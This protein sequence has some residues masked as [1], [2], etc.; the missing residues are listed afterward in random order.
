M[1]DAPENG[2]ANAND[3]DEQF[4]IHALQLSEKTMRRTA[5]NPWVGAVIVAADGKTIL[6]EGYHHGPGKPH[7]EVEAFRDAEK[8]GSTTEQ[9]ATSTL[10]TTLEPCH[11]GVGKR[12][13]PCDEMIVSRKV[14]RCV[15]GL[16]DPDP[17]FGG[18]GIQLMR[19]AGIDVETGVAESKVKHSLRAYFQHRRHATPFVILKIAT[20]LDGRVSCA[21]GT[22]QW[23]TKSAARQDTHRLRADSQAIL[24]GSGT[25]LQDKPSLTVRLPEDPCVAS[26]PLRVVLD[27]HGRVRDG[28][29]MDTSTA[30]T[31]VFT[32]G[33]TC[34][35]E[36][37]LHWDAKGVQYCDVPLLPLACENKH[38]KQKQVLDIQAVLQELAKRGVLQLMVE[39]GAVLQGEFL[40]HGF[41][42][43]LRVYLGATLLGSTAQPWAQTGLTQ[44]IGDA[45]FWR[46]RT[47]RK[48]EDDV[49]MEYEKIQA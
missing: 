6:G 12:T 2:L 34:P 11:R 31:L 43:E 20:S 10:Y 48:L 7:A 28:P 29:L 9:L 8:K 4:M 44:T 21:D 37:R 49:C 3:P 42:D 35:T 26:Q 22:S 17:V 45:K 47:V 14:R 27:T 41:V 1:A 46:L 18:A 13:P 24:V 39:G 33:E 38:G 25:A 30:P 19:E 16:V 5:P 36:A 32:N 15:V 23:I 40:R